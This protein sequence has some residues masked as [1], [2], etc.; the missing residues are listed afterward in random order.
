MLRQDIYC[1]VKKHEHF[2]IYSP[3]FLSIYTCL[4]IFSHVYQDGEPLE[5]R[6]QLDEDTLTL[7][8]EC[9]VL[10]QMLVDFKPSLVDELGIADRINDVGANVASV[11]VIWR[12]ELQ[13]RF[14][15]I[16]KLCDELAPSSKSR[17]VNEIDRS[18]L[19]NKLL[20][21]IQRSEDLYREITYQQKL[22]DMGIA[23][24]FSLTNQERA[25]WIA[26]SISCLINLLFL[27]FYKAEDDGT[28]PTTYMPAEVETV[29]IAP[30]SHFIPSCILRLHLKISLYLLTSYSLTELLYI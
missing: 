26:F 19:E 8:A 14:F 28:T 10:L 25:T 18:N 30:V 27:I 6:D 5:D 1:R 17:L 7:Y 4:L 16:P 24:I 13:R 2:F 21:F 11:E 3:T 15:Q 29:R 22:K 9:L 20:E 23:S 12:G